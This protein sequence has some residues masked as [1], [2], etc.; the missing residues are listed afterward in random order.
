MKTHL[1]KVINLQKVEKNTTKIKR[2]RPEQYY[3]I[4]VWNN[5]KDKWNY[6]EMN[7]IAKTYVAEEN[8]RVSRRT[9]EGKRMSAIR[10]IKKK[11]RKNDIDHKALLMD[12]LRMK[13]M[14][15]LP[16]TKRLVREA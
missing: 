6:N 13:A 8:A 3:E 7:R 16:R 1:K 15:V 4:N 2:L 10:K 12:A 5:T 11:T 14:R 9:H